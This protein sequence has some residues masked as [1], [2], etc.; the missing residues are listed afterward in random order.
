MNWR[1]LPGLFALLMLLATAAFVIGATVEQNQGR[2][3]TA[4]VTQS[5][6]QAQEEGAEAHEGEEA[7][8]AEGSEAATSPEEGAET[9]LGVNLERTPVI[10]LGA[11]VSLALAG[12]VLRWPR[13]GILAAAT[14]FCVASAVLDGREVAHQLDED[15]GGLA[16]LAVLALVLHLGAALVAALALVRS[17]GGRAD[18]A[19]A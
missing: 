12:V 5:E 19:A 18:V 7:A 4:E 8:G 11:L 10:V 3:E 1:G 2:S 13:G 6:A 17:R 14:L 16:A 15:A 9:V